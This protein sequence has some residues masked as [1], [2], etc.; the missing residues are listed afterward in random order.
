M[1][2]F[3]AL[4]TTVA[5][6]KIS[7]LKEAPPAK[8]ESCALVAPTNLE[9]DLDAPKVVTGG[10]GAPS[11]NMAGRPTP[12]ASRLWFVATQPPVRRAGHHPRPWNASGLF[13][14]PLS[15]D[16]EGAPISHTYTSHYGDPHSKEGDHLM[17]TCGPFERQ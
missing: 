3:N 17:S 16:W 11:V 8:V 4:S 7:P 6:R 14:F 1:D 12:L 10:A 15:N 9:K 5:A 13:S 2:P